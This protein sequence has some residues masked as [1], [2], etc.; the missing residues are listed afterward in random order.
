[1][2]RSACLLTLAASLLAAFP[3][4]TPG[5]EKESP[6]RAAAKMI[7]PAADKAIERGLAFLVSRQHA[8]GTFGTGGYRGNVAV[9][10]LCGLAFM[11]NGST[12]GRGPYGANVSLTLDYVLAN[13]QE[14][15]FIISQPYAQHGPMYGHGFATMFLGECYGMSPRPETREK[16]AKAVKLIVNV[17]NDVGGWRYFPQRMEADMSVTGCE[18]MA[19]R[20]ARNAGIFVPKETIEKSLGYVKKS[21][22][23]DG[24]FMYMLTNGGG[25]MFPRSA[26][27]VVSLYSLGVYE[28]PEV[29]KGLDYVTKF[30]PQ[31]GVVRQEGFYFYGHYYAALAM[32]QAGG[33][34]WAKWYPAI[35]DELIAQQ[36]PGGY[37]VDD[38]TSNEFAT[39]MAL[40]I[41]QMPNNYLPIFQR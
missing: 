16:L 24:G 12:P 23:P 39:A 10:S 34:R 19:L 26:A 31:P 15:G 13:T 29:T 8:D 25:S 37:W 1:M 4:E 6:E 40:I 27:G 3:L 11:A 18:I 21:Q 36:R 33:E 35:R 41:L 14:S 17:Q 9:V 30:I 32:W 28:G 5:A 7:T 20:A 2:P 22:N 38:S